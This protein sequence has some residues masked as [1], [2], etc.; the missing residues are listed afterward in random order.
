MR[1]SKFGKNIVCEYLGGSH[2]YNLNTVNSD[3]D[4]RGV[5]LTD[6]TPALFGFKKDETKVNQSDEED[7]AYFELN[8]FL[9]KLKRTNTN[10]IEALFAPEDSFRMKTPVFDMIQKNYKRLMDSKALMHSLKGHVFNESKHARGVRTGHLG[11]A[12]KAALDKH[13]FS[14][15]NVSHMIRL[16][17]CGEQF[18]KTGVFPVSLKGTPVFD[19]CLRLKTHPE[20]FEL[21]EVSKLC[22]E[23]IKKVD[24]LEDTVGY[25]FDNDFACEVL[26]YGYGGLLK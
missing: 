10:S 13:G 2:L 11:G 21:S 25:T 15:K 19:I 20:E 24:K 9:K 1:T 14:P 4:L 17:Y 5:Y 22:E 6:S 16:A 18:F 3:I 26:L 12:R 23:Q 7:Y 8:Y